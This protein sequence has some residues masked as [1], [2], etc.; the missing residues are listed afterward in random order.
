MVELIAQFGIAIGVFASTNIDDI[1]LLA[2]FFSD[3]ELRVRSIVLGQCLGIGLLVAVSC[4]IAFFSLALPPGYVSFLGVLPLYL[5]IRK[6]PS[7]WTVTEDAKE[8]ENVQTQEKII[9]KNTGS[10][11]MAVSAVTLA[12]GGDNL[13]VYIPMFANSLSSIPL[14]V[15]IFAIMTLL[16]CFLGHVLV[17]N[18][19]AGHW[20]RRY[21]HKVLPVVLIIL[22]LH[23]LGDAAFQ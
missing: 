3:K 12:N 19:I 15:L 4:I 17:N 7:L 2:A 8:E 16:W 5:G 22:G 20:I 1:F 21:G 13:G 18:K 6:L 14:F 11:I 23:I 10:Q 9:E